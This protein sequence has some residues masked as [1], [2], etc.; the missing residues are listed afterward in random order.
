M[1]ARSRSTLFGFLSLLIPILIFF[2]TRSIFASSILWMSWRLGVTILAIVGI[3]LGVVGLKKSTQSKLTLVTRIF[4]GIG[5]LLGIAISFNLWSIKLS[6]VTGVISD[7]RLYEKG[8][9]NWP[10]IRSLRVQIDLP[11]GDFIERNLDLN[12]P[13]FIINTTWDTL[14]LE[15]IGEQQRRIVNQDQ[16]ETN[17]HIEIEYDGWIWITDPAQIDAIVIRILDR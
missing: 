2:G 15:H 4:C 11:A 16:L 13:V 6:K 8:Q 17:Q 14:V 12:D 3:F 10:Y 7:V 5:I 1:F 9:S